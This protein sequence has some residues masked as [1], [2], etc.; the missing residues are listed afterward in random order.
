MWGSPF[1]L[2]MIGL[3]G[4]FKVAGMHTSEAVDLALFLI[5]PILLVLSFPVICFLA[6]RRFGATIGALFSLLLLSANTT[7]HAFSTGRGDHHGLILLTHLGLAAAFTWNHPK[8]PIVAGVLCG[9]SMWASCITTLPIL[10]IAAVASTVARTI[11]RNQRG[12]DWLLFGVWAAA[13]SAIAWAIDFLPGRVIP[14][15]LT[16]NNLVWSLSVLGGAGLTWWFQQRLVFSLPA[17]I[18]SIRALPA[19]LCFFILGAMAPTLILASGFQAFS[20]MLEENRVFYSFISELSAQQP[21]SLILSSPLAFTVF[22]A[23]AVCALFLSPTFTKEARAN[24]WLALIFAAGALFLWTSQQR[25][26]AS[27]V[28]IILLASA[29]LLETCRTNVSA[30]RLVRAVCIFACLFA[31]LSLYFKSTTAVRAVRAISLSQSVGQ[32]IAG[33]L[34]A[35]AAAILADGTNARGVLTAPDLNPLLS[36]YT[37]RHSL[38]GFFLNVNEVI[39]SAAILNG[40]DTNSS[41]ELLNAYDIG[42]VVIFGNEAP[43]F[44]YLLASLFYPDSVPPEQTLFARLIKE[45]NRPEWITEISDTVTYG[46]RARVFRVEPATR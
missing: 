20:P 23:S 5:S 19:L 21:E 17:N 27:S 35:T 28:P 44:L 43:P 11:D 7:L 45:D 24:T 6:Q 1:L 25:W 38:A 26:G 3:S 46:A 32:P 15:N 16:G 33:A 31:C 29:M 10:A 40:L 42:Y 36:H 13:I 34:R 41:R 12:F 2:L 8:A 22:A 37:G 30:A 14:I 39:E 4:L 9:L 18:G